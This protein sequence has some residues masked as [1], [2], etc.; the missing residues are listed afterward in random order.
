MDDTVLLSTSRNN[1][2]KMIGV[3]QEYCEEYG[4]AV[5]SS[6]TYFFVIYGEEKDVEPMQVD[7]M[8]VELC[9]SYICWGSPFTCDGSA[10]SA[11]RLQAKSKLCHELKYIS[12][13]KIIMMY[14]LL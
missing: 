1:M 4:M 7:E 2:V 3:L 9:T 13:I 11:V 8:V 10:S 5:N 6:K 14:H 12:R